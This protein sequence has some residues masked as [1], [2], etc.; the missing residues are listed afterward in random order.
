MPTSKIHDYRQSYSAPATCKVGARKGQETLRQ[1]LERIRRTE[2]DISVGSYRRL[3]DLPHD[4][5]AE[6][7]AN[8]WED[9][10]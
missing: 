6:Y 9:A 5:W 2:K 4:E 8:L 1:F 10:E 3:I 7:V